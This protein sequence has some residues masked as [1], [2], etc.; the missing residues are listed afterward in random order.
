MIGRK[1]S[2]SAFVA[3]VFVGWLLAVPAAAFDIQR[4]KSTGGIEAWLIEDH[5]NPIISMRFAFRGGASLDPVGEEGLAEMVSGLLD[6]GAGPLD[7]RAFQQKLEDMAIT[8]RFDAG[9]D[10]F[11][12]RLRT[13][14]RHR[15][16][17]LDLLRLAV[18]SPRFDDEPVERIRSQIQANLRRQAEDPDV[19][20]RRQL[21]TKLFPAHPYGRP[22]SGTPESI[23]SISA[24]HLR[25]FVSRRIAKK[26][27]V[28]GV[29]GDITADDLRVALDWVFG[30]LPESGTDWAVA[31]A[32]PS[33]VGGT[34][35]VE[36]AVP[37]SSIVFGQRGLKRNHP[38][39]YTAYVLNHIFGGGGFSSRLYN[40][41]RE[42]RGLAYSVYSALLPLD[43]AGL[44]FGGAGTRNDRAGETVDIIRREWAHMAT[45]G[46]T[47][48]ELADA[49]LYLTGSFPL[50]FSSSERIAAILVAIQLDDLG[51]DYLNRRNSLIEAV[52]LDDVRRVAAEILDPEGLTFVVAGKPEGL[53]PD[54]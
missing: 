22:V 44:F 43:H 30:D 12:G 48:E 35:V 36:T 39:Y 38:D 14:T 3:L 31:D 6:E 47:A 8:L 40:E 11:G 53:S 37:Q 25:G 2:F 13:L 41:V 51:I 17:A 24:D 9:R 32:S 34:T 49:K 23:A 28:I 19:T 46:P 33:P 26:G 42:K 50:R 52:T 18:T 7:S 1:W 15:D 20:A 45:E 54:G 27:L 29:V 4:V 5:A 21:F 10:T 16:A